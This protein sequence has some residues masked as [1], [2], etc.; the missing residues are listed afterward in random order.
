MKRQMQHR[1]EEKITKYRNMV[2]YVLMSGS[3]LSRLLIYNLNFYNE[4]MLYTFQIIV[5][6]TDMF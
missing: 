5:C 1:T 4:F 6:S 3:L 2:W